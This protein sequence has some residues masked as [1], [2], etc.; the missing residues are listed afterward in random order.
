VTVRHPEVEV[1]LSGCDGNAF[2]I[3]G[4]VAGALRRAGVPEEEVDA[5]YAES[6]EGDY[7]HLL[8]TAFRWVTVN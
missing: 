7:D 5:Y 3:M 4:R 8:I 6:Q 1:Q 2:A